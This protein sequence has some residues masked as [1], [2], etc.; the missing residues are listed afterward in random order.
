MNR[1]DIIVCLLCSTVRWGRVH[2]QQ[3]G[4]IYSI[5]IIGPNEQQYTLSGSSF[6]E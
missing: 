3:T 1:R 6:P 2:A 5:A 4:K